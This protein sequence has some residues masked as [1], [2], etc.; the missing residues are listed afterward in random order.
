MIV[1]ARMQLGH[2]APVESLTP[3]TLQTE[4]FFVTGRNHRLIPLIALP[5]AAT[6]A[7]CGGSSTNPTASTSSSAAATPTVA[8]PTA[9][10]TA[11]TVA[12]HC[13]SGSTVGS[14]LGITLPDA[15]NVVGGNT[16][17]LPPGATGI[18]CD[19]KGASNNVLITALVNI[20]ASYI[21]SFSQH[22]PVAFKTVSGVGDVARSFFEPLGAGKNNEGLVAAKGTTVIA[23]VATYTPATL[24]QLEALVNSL[25]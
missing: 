9:T 2:S 12:A 22:F 4:G 15:T 24:S 18:V 3:S 11:S 1:R 10:A 23:I 20:P 21:S 14:A 16:A 6:L 7:A 19:Y 13:P 8:A 17:S 5:F 25:L